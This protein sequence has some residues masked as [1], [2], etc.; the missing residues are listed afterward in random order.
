MTAAEMDTEYRTGT[1]EW[2]GG[3]GDVFRDN[4]LCDRCD[5]ATF[6][7][8]IC[9]ERYH[10]DD[11]CR[12]ISQDSNFEWIGSGV[13]D[14]PSDETRKSLLQLFDLLPYS[15]ASDLR[16]AIRSGRFHTFF[17]A[18]LVGQGIDLTL[19]GMPDRTGRRWMERE[20][21]DALVR[22]GQGPRA[23]E[24][25]DGYSWLASLYDTDTLEA[26]AA[27]VEVIDEFLRTRGTG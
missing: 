23:E 2:C 26:N 13:Q 8:A 20:W 22:V 11:L 24:T 3:E 17:V 9:D 15:F 25:S 10:E 16:K 12:H 27:T 7:C 21:G 19:Y 5:A 14:A 4:S 6:H 18:G 1:C